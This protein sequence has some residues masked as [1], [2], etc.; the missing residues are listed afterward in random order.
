RR[1][2]QGRASSGATG[3]A[4]RCRAPVRP[5]AALASDAA[6]APDVQ[7]CDGKD[8][9]AGCL[10]QQS[11]TNM[12]FDFAPG[13]AR[14]SLKRQWLEFAE[15]TQNND[16]FALL[17]FR[18]RLD[19]VAGKIKGDFGIWLTWRRKVQGA[20]IYRDFAAADAKKTA[21]VDHRGTDPTVAIDDDVD[22]AAHIFV[23]GAEN[24]P[25]EHA[26]DFM[27]IEHRHRR[28]FHGSGRSVIRGIAG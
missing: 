15:R 9:S 14:A 20:P 2:S 22:Y 26:L 24:W 27:V 21:E 16:G 17:I 23:G 19:L 11:C 18:G 1:T 25:P 3:P 4:A 13:R 5:S 10:L 28:R 8:L 7:R 12:R 6:A